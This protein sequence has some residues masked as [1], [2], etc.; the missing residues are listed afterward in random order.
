[1]FNAIHHN[2]C[3]GDCN[4]GCRRE[5][6][7]FYTFPAPLR[8]HQERLDTTQLTIHEDIIKTKEL[9]KKGCC[10]PELIKFSDAKKSFI[11]S[12]TTQ[13]LEPGT[14]YTLQIDRE[15]PIS[16]F[17]L[18]TYISVEPCGFFRGE[19][20]LNFTKTEHW[21]PHEHIDPLVGAGDRDRLESVE[22]DGGMNDH[23]A[24]HGGHGMM[25][26]EHFDGG[27]FGCA[28]FIPRDPAFP[29]QEFVGCGFKSKHGI[30]VPVVLD[31][32]G[33]IATGKNFNTGRF[34]VPGVGHPYN[35]RFVLYY[36]NA[37]KF[38][39]SRDFKRR[40]DFA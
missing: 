32:H 15:V 34:A 9:A 13:R 20:G 28:G 35:N 38:V 17:P 40:S 30:L 22:V 29:G 4:C 18:D 36:N 7:N 1:M 6:V 19:V 16:A 26:D 8:K 5:R 23:E 24:I 27:R 10:H 39:L 11:I 21:R 25:T 37:G 33:N 31:L 14:Y 3:H 12:A 2:R